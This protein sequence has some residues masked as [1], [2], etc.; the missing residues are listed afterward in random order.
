MV[1]IHLVILHLIIFRP[2]SGPNGS[3]LKKAMKALN[4]ASIKSIAES[5]GE[6][7]IDLEIID[8]MYSI[9]EITMFVAGPQKAVEPTTFIVVGLV[10]TTAPGA[11]NFMGSIGIADTSVRREPI[12]S[13]L[14]YA[15]TLFLLATIL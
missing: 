9:M 2:S 13:S 10:R 7:N 6:I 8:E 12:G 3:R 11:M 15:L 5:R 1:T 14:K 4:L